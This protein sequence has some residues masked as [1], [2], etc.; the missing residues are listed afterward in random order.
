MRRKYIEDCE[1]LLLIPDRFNLM[2]KSA[3]LFLFQN[4]R[5]RKN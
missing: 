5:K 1:R 4:E 3:T 2:N